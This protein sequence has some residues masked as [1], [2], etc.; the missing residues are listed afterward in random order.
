MTNQERKESKILA[1]FAKVEKAQAEIKGQVNV[2]EFN[3]KWDT[4]INSEEGKMF[5]QKA[6]EEVMK[7]I[8]KSK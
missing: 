6:T 8:N 1:Y 4:F 5:I 2:D 7:A 3:A